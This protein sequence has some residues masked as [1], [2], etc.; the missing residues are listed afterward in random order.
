MIGRV[1]EDL[2]GH[3]LKVI[4]WHIQKSDEPIFPIIHKDEHTSLQADRITRDPFILSVYG[5]EYRMNMASPM[6]F[7]IIGLLKLIKYNPKNDIRWKKE[8]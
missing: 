8:E 4:D 6:G 2:H 3:Q 5:D 1:I 7:R